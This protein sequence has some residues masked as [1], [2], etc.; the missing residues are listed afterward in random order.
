MNALQLRAIPCISPISL[1][2]CPSPSHTTRL[3]ATQSDIGS[4]P[5]SPLSRKKSITVLSDDGR[6]QWGDLSR[7]EKVARTTQQSFNFIIVLAGAVLTVWIGTFSRLDTKLLTTRSPYRAGSLHFSIS[8]C[9]HQI[10][11]H[12]NSKKQCRALKMIP[13]VS[14]YSVIGGKF[15]HMAKTPGVDG[16]GTD[17]LRESMN[18]ATVSSTGPVLTINRSRTE[19]DRLGREHLHMHFHVRYITQFPAIQSFR[20]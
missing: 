8:R 14:S 12:G 4:G 1:R 2:L 13:S 10:V 20:C 18:G 7:G 3:Y 15:K 16:L 6:V 11:E 19:K 5:K 17:R 9:S